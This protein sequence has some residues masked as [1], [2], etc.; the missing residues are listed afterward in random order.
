[1]L[2]IPPS[3]LAWSLPGGGSKG[4]DT[5]GRINALWRLRPHLVRDTRMI[6]ATS[7]GSLI[8]AKM[9]AAIV[10][11]DSKHIVDLTK[12]YGSVKDGDILQGATVGGMAATLGLKAI[13]GGESVYSTEPLSELIDRH[14]SAET[15]QAI[16][17]AG[18]RK[19]KPFEV[20]FT[21]A[22]MQTGKLEIFTNRSHPDKEILK[23]AL[24]ASASEPVFTNLVEINGHEYADGGLVDINPVG[25]LFESELIKDVKGIIAFSLQAEKEPV[26]FKSYRNIIDALGRTIDILTATVL[27]DDIKTAHLI[28]TLLHLRSMS[29][30]DSWTK[31]VSTLPEDLKVLATDKLAGKQYVPILHLRPKDPITMTGLEFKQPAM[32]NQ[33]RKAF[34]EVKQELRG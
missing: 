11:G 5:V 10:T 15:W 17:D 9:S 22:N 21:A 34:Q 32:R 2:T 1:M 16:I 19:D 33:M 7:T 23:K 4:C 26:N 18:Q 12:I 30:A 28:N 3:P 13:T 24:L 31:A 29:S 6:Y 14:M 25:R 27:A 8:G 20:G